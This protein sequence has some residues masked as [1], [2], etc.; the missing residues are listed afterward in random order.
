MSEWINFVMA[1]VLV[2]LGV[3]FVMLGMQIIGNGVLA[4]LRWLLS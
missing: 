3:F 2:V 4:A 1:P